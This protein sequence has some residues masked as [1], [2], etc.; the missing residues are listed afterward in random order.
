M[1]NKSEWDRIRSFERFANAAFDQRNN[2]IISLRALAVKYGFDDEVV[3]IFIETDR[4]EAQELVGYARRSDFIFGDVND[5]AS[6][7]ENK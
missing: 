2:Y 3:K 1:D 5:D 7:N 4:E 6:S